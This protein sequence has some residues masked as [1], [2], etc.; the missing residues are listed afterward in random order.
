M[1]KL[2]IGI[3]DLVARGPTKSLYGRLHA[4][5]PREHHA[6]GGRRLVRRSRAMTS[7]FVCYTGFEDLTEELPPI[8]TSL[9]IERLHPGRPARLRAQQPVP[10]ARRGH[11]PGRAPRPLLSRRTARKYFDYVLGFTDKASS[12]TCSRTAA[13]TGRWACI[14]PPARQP[15]SLPGVRE[16][17]KFIEPTLAKAP[18]S[19]SCPCWA[20]WAAPTPA[21]SASI[22]SVPYQ[23]LDFDEMQRGSA[24][25]AHQV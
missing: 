19:R 5:E 21:A 10:P 4:R 25:P 20:A 23:P 6:P 11:R 8:S 14:W 22:P 3:V 2:R 16:R 15:Q 17:W 24:L 18:S 1:T 12:A 13:R 7:S 9:F